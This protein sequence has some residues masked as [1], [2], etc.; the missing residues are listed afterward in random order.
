MTS[1]AKSCIMRLR[2]REGLYL[3]ISLDELIV[4]LVSVRPRSRR[5]IQTVLSSFFNVDPKEVT[6]ALKRLCAPDDLGQVKLIQT[7]VP[8]GRKGLEPAHIYSGRPLD[9][10]EFASWEQAYQNYLDV[11]DCNILR[12]AGEQYARA[13][14]RKSGLF[15][16]V[17]RIKRLGRIP[18]ANGFIDFESVHNP[19]GRKVLWEV[20]NVC[21][22]YYRKKRAFRKL[23]EQAEA[24]GAQ[25]ALIA[26]NLS[27]DAVEYCEETGIYAVRLGAQIL[28]RSLRPKVETPEIFQI[29]GPATFQYIANPQPSGRIRPIKG[30]PNKWQR[31]HIAEIGDETKWAR[32]FNRW[33]EYAASKRME[34]MGSAA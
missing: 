23:I 26:A 7:P 22:P 12:E 11:F 24:M 10:V 25:P 5:F 2:R 28:P 14:V 30:R 19:T 18:V 21:E 17:S 27:E 16:G 20:K 13:L 15:R 8:L 34:L 6:E 1:R 32:C 3:F 9:L 29:T 4:D 33:D 31:E